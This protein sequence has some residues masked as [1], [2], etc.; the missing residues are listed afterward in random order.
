MRL[1]EPREVPVREQSV[2]F[3]LNVAPNYPVRGEGHAGHLPKESVEKRE[4]GPLGKDGHEADIESARFCPSIVWEPATVDAVPNEPGGPPSFQQV[5]QGGLT[6]RGRPGYS[7]TEPAHAAFPLLS[8]RGAPIRVAKREV[9]DVQQGRHSC[10]APHRLQHCRTSAHDEASSPH[11]RSRQP[12]KPPNDRRFTSAQPRVDDPR[13]PRRETEHRRASSR[14]DSVECRRRSENTSFEDDGKRPPLTNTSDGRHEVS[15]AS[16]EA[17]GLDRGG[18]V[19]HS[20]PEITRVGLHPAKPPLG[21]T[22]NR[23]HPP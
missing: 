9:H 21:A 8:C 20:E 6:V 18:R 5:F 11:L 12:S 1:A 15:F 19:A 2:E 10:E 17:R 4:I 14:E 22:R 23:G 13:G 7:T 3:V 16:P